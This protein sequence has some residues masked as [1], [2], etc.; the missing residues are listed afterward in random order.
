MPISNPHS[1][2]SFIKSASLAL[3]GTA[4]SRLWFPALSPAALTQRPLDEF[5]YADVSIT[6]ELHEQQLRESQSV[7]MS[8]SEDSLLK[9]FREMA[10]QPAP[11]QGLGGWYRYNPDF[12][13]R[14]ENWEGFS[15]AASFGQWISALARGYAI[16]GSEATR[17]KV[18]RLNQLYAKAISHDFFEKNR[19]PAYC[20]DKIVCGLIDSHKYAGDANAFAILNH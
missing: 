12:D 2:W 7:L 8:L 10:G 9:P 13:Y 6:S 11:G 18:V 16:N 20:Y 14:Q 4:G 5:T 17:E 1:R 15:P 19:F 3:A